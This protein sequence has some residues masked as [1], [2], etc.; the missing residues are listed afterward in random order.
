MGLKPVVREASDQAIWITVDDIELALQMGFAEIKVY[1]DTA[2]D[3]NFSNALTDTAPLVAN[4]TEYV[5]R[6]SSPTGRYYKAVLN[7][8]GD[9]EGPASTIRQYGTGCGYATSQDVRRELSASTGKAQLSPRHGCTIW[10]MVEEASRLVDRMRR[11]PDGGYR[12][13]TVSTYYFD[14]N[15]EGS[16]WLPLPLVSIT[17]VAVEE[18]DGTYTNWTE[19]TDYFAWPYNETPYLR[20]DVNR[21]SDTTKSTWIAGPRRV[22]VQGVFGC[23]STPPEEIRRAVLIQVARWYKR[24]TAGW[25]DATGNAE[26]GELRYVKKMDPDVAQLVHHA[27][28]HEVRL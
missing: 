12:A 19:N 21:K 28:P 13:S 4:T 24:A 11:L 25:A 7:K 27:G 22:R 26:T 1:Y 8:S 18:T 16:L 15:G 17:Q 2:E 23:S 9:S 20:L 10:D 14:G 5:L 3:G 6:D